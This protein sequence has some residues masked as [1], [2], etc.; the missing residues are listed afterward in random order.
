[1]EGVKW[2]VKRE[3]QSM[4]KSQM[5]AFAQ[6]LHRL[7]NN[8]GNFR[9]VAPLNLRRLRVFRAQRVDVPLVPDEKNSPLSLGPNARTDSEF[10]TLR[11]AQKAAHTA[12]ESQEYVADFRNRLRRSAKAYQNAVSADLSS[13]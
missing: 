4:G 12:E 2:L 5:E 13:T 11:W 6:T 7:T 8:D 1:M 9:A 3:V 10:R